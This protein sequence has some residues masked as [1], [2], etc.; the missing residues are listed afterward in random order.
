[1]HFYH[2]DDPA[3]DVAF[4]KG[5]KI[6]CKIALHSSQSGSINEGDFI[7]ISLT[8]GVKYKGRIVAFNPIWLKNVA[9]GEMTV[10]K[11]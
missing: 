11:V 2:F 9:F 3:M 6:V 1:M 10:Q 4:L 7:A 8:N 5:E